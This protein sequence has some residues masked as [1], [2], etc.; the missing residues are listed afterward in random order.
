MKLKSIEISNYKSIKE[1]IKIDLTDSKP[2]VFTGKNGCGKTNLLEAIKISLSERGYYLD[3]AKDIKVKRIYQL[4]KEEMEEYFS[5]TEEEAADKNLDEIEVVFD[6]D[7]PDIE[8]AQ[9]PAIQLSVEKFR[10][11]LEKVKAEFDVSTKHYL[12]IIEGFLMEIGYG[13]FV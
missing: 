10:P 8:L 3:E 4:D 7:D 2:T 12:D 6:H 5:L 11:R 9:V 1:P 13:K